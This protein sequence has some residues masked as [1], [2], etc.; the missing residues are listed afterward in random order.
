MYVL[1]LII[2]FIYKSHNHAFHQSRVQNRAIVNRD[3]ETDF[4]RFN[5][6][7]FKDVTALFTSR[8]NVNE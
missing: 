2:I 5:V 7:V 8:R 4:E 1:F 6:N 3:T